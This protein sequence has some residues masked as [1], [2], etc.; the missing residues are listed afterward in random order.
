MAPAQR[1]VVPAGEFYNITKMMVLVEI[2][3]RETY[4][5]LA[6][7]YPP[8]VGAGLPARRGFYLQTRKRWGHGLWDWV[9][10]GC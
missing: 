7:F 9:F 8:A 4:R 2:T 5:K 6:G 1:P 10:V 3:R